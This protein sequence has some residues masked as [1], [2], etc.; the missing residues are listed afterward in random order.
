[1]GCRECRGMV[2][3]MERVTECE[4]EERVAVGVVGVAPEVR[5]RL[6]SFMGD[7]ARGL[8][9]SEQ[10][11]CAELYARGLLEAGARKSLEPI[12]ARLGE[13]GDYEALQ[14]FLADSP[15]DPVVIQRAVAE[16]VAAEIGVEAW[17]IDDTGVV[18]GRQAFAGGQ[19]PV[20]RDARQDR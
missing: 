17:V 14:H 10:R 6:V 18:E 20:F 9:R 5:E 8:V 4:G 2:T 11:R 15:W 1:M 7:V 19:A 3:V 12:V 13:D 16:R